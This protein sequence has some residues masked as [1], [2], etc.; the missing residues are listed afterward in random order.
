MARPVGWRGGPAAGRWVL[1][2]GGGRPTTAFSRRKFGGL[3]VSVVLGR[4]LVV[5]VCGLAVGAD[6]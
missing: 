1:A 2:T 3:A 6:R 4:A 5:R